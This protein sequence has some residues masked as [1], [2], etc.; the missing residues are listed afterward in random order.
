MNK[1]VLPA[2]WIRGQAGAGKG[3]GGGGLLGSRQEQAGE[4][5]GV[6]INNSE[7]VS[8]AGNSRGEKPSRYH[9]ITI[10]R[11]GVQDIGGLRGPV[12]YRWGLPYPT[13]HTL[14]LRPAGGQPPVGLSAARGLASLRA[15]F[16]FLVI[17]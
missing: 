12:R 1:Y 8:R 6:S 10:Y 5:W 17:N 13:L 2:E 11:R 15:N 9:D 4:D 7:M 14:P 16:V 3:E